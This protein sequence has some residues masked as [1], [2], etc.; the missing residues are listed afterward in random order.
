MSPRDAIRLQRWLLGH[1]DLGVT[2]LRVFDPWPQVAYADCPDAVVGLCRKMEGRTSGI[3]TG[4]QPRAVHLFDRAPNRWA[5]SHRGLNGNCAHDCNI[6]YISAI[7]F[8]LDVKSLQR[9]N[10]HPASQDELAKTLR[11]AKWLTRQDGLAMSSVTCCSGNGHCV[12]APIVP[13]P[14]DNQEIAR[15][16]R[17]FC[18]H[19]G[20]GV[21]DQF[22]GV[23]VDSVYNLSRV[24]RIMGT[25]NGKGDPVPGRP[26]RRA[27]FVTEPLPV[28]SVLLHHMILSTEV[29]D[30]A[31]AE[32]HLSTGLKCDLAAVEG[33]EFILYC[34]RDARA[35]SE[36]QWFALITNLARLQGGIPL[37]HQIS[38]LDSLRYDRAK[39][40]RVIDRVFRDGYKPASCRMIVGPAMDRPGRGVFQCSRIGTC[41]VRAPMYLATSHTV[42]TR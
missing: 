27:H 24:M 20:D 29:A 8:D 2:E 15:K 26:H 35:V 42:Y 16:F 23:R 9:Q 3:Y 25:L 14:V 10:G 38:A 37:I 12:L 41:A 19:L 28:R 22:K 32:R 7:Y 13:I 21:T 4:V 33:C 36:P 30:C 17:S 39:T 34:R 5:S 11:A 6:E 18:Q 1:E 40:Q 31:G